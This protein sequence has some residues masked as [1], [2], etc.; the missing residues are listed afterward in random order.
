[1]P[2]SHGLGLLDEPNLEDE[3]AD[4]IIHTINGATEDAQS[5]REILEDEENSRG[6]SKSR[7]RGQKKM[8]TKGKGSIPSSNL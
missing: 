8:N 4:S 5:D 7:S 1:M 3:V 6:R 2:K